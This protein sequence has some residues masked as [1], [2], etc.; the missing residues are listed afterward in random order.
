MTFIK[1]G[2]LPGWVPG[3][4]E[5]RDVEQIKRE[6][7]EIRDEPFDFVR[8]SVVRW[9]FFFVLERSL[10]NRLGALNAIVRRLCGAFIE[11]RL[12]HGGG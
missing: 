7:E 6:S 10:P 8:K 5:L 2:R 11:P 12:L 9:S 1:V 4:G 3:F